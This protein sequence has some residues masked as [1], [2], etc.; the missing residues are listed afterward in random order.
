MSIYEIP[1]S[2]NELFSDVSENDGYI[3]YRIIDYSEGMSMDN[4][5]SLT[6]FLEQV[7]I[8]TNYVAEDH[9]TLVIL[10]HPEYETRVAI[11][12][13]GLGDFFSHQFEA[14]WEEE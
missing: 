10:E 2:F 1:S 5:E 12:S 8:H 4:N 14:S 13:G 3:Q 11:H 7:D 9:G 6:Y